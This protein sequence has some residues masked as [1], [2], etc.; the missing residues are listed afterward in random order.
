MRLYTAR[1]YQLARRGQVTERF[2]KALERLGSDQ[3]YVRIGGILAL[4]QIVQDV[5]DQVATDAA[6]VLNHFLR[7]HAA[8]KS[9][10]TDGKKTDVS[11][12]AADDEARLQAATCTW[13]TP[14]P[15]TEEKTRTDPGLPDELAAD[16]QAALT[17][18]TGPEFRSHV[19]VGLDLHGLHLAGACLPEADLTSANLKGANLAG[20]DLSRPT[21][22]GTDLTDATLTDCADLTGANL[23]RA[24]LYGADLSGA[25]LRWAILTNAEL[26]EA[27]LTEA[28]LFGANLTGA[29]LFTTT[30]TGANLTE[31]VLTS[32]YLNGTNLIH[33]EGLTSEQVQS[34]LRID[35][36]ILPP[37]LRRQ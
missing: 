23:A 8:P 19:D 24:R 15:S 25:S 35:N 6:R 28:T 29:K 26:A 21:V 12:H 4:E 13:A 27:N 3:A 22:T 10:T 20:A 34:A 5:P 37:D 7:H 31:A 33:T 18:L 14:S 17:A 16:V 11:P 1:T 9:P 30:L 2:T 32:A 36:A